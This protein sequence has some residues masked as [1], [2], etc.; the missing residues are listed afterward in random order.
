MTTTTSTLTEIPQRVSAPIKWDLKASRANPGKP[1]KLVGYASVFNQRSHDLGGFTE[2][3]APSAFDRVLADPALDVVLLADHAGLPLAR[4]TA[5]TLKLAAD[6][7]GLR[8]EADLAPTSMARDVYSLIA[9]GHLEEMSFSFLPGDEEWP[10]RDFCRVLEVRKLLDVTVATRGAYPQTAVSARSHGVH[11]IGE[12]PVYGPGSTS[13]Y[14]RDR[15]AIAYLDTP[16]S[17][18]PPPPGLGAIR[19]F[20]ASETFPPPDAAPEHEIRRRLA[21]VTGARERA[22]SSTAG[23]GGEFEPQNVPDSIAAKYAISATAE[24][25]LA[26][27]LGSE[28]I[29]ELAGGKIV[30]P[31]LAT[32]TSVSSQADGSATSSTDATS[33]SFSSVPSYITGQQ[34]ISQQLLDLS[35]PGFDEVIAADLG[36]RNGAELDRQIVNGSGTNAL[37]GFLNI[38]GTTGATAFTAASPKPAELVSKIGSCFSAVSVAIGHPV[39]LITFATRRWAWLKSQA[40]EQKMPV[41]FE[42]LAPE[43]VVPATPITVNTNQ[44]PVFVI[45]SRQIALFLNAPIISVAVDASI[46]GNLQVRISFRQ[47]CAMIVRNPAGLGWVVGTGTTTPTFA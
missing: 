47:A 17:D 5:G 10:Q 1:P 36:A 42:S 33:T 6:R 23:A 2:E 27:A 24:G 43:L 11:V 3:I 45:D 9:S 31:A 30:I 40:D 19:G 38:S 32:G 21:T 39:D 4:T 34:P 14:F 22:L 29:P 37:K 46:D 18:E 7:T 35:Q 41:T 26:T 16:A 13:S 25:T 8:V 12:R 20:A 44:D 28:P 15:A